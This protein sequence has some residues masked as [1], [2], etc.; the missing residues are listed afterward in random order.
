MARRTHGEAQQTR[1]R[2]LN[3][4]SLAFCSKGVSSTSLEDVARKALVTRGAVYWHFKDKHALLAELL[5]SIR[6]PTEHVS[7]SDSLK[8]ACDHLSAALLETARSQSIRRVL[9]I[10][11]C[12][13][14]WSE[15]Q[16][17]VKRRVVRARRQM[18]AHL[19]TVFSAALTR[20]E[21]RPGIAPADLGLLA[22]AFQAGMTGLLFELAQS[23]RS[24]RDDLHVQSV[25]GILYAS[26]ARAE[27][28]A[29]VSHDAAPAQSSTAGAPTES[30]A[31]PPKRP[32]AR[33]VKTVESGGA[34][35]ARRGPATPPPAGTCSAP[36]PA[37]PRRS[38]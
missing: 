28:A 33:P 8:E 32:V 3:A 35:P 6:M 38:A 15:A 5:E 4:A 10:I 29:A 18:N 37:A 13:V 9:R 2:I 22:D 31:C 21:L 14:E 25:M 20:G 23:R 17:C 19:M 34:G 30:I 7:P 16:P 12:K 36:C 27:S 11:L 1:Q 24:A 26:C